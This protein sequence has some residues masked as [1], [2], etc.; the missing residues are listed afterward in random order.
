[1]AGR[2]R[3]AV[4]V[5]GGITGALTARELAEAGWDVTVLEAEHT[6]A[7]SSSRTAAGIRQ[8]FSTETTVRGMRYSVGFYERF[9][10]RVGGTVVPIQQQG[11][12]FL[13]DDEEALRRAGDRVAMQRAAGLREVELLDGDEVRRRHPWVDGAIVGA[14]FCPT[15]GFLLPEVVYNEAMEAARRLGAQVVQRAPVTGGSSEG[16]RLTA[17]ETPRGRFGAD[18]FVDATNAWTRR[19]ARAL[20]AEPLDVT[21]YKRFLWFLARGGSM[22]AD[23]LARMPMT[24]CPSGV[25]CRPENASSLMVG[26]VLD[27][28]PEPD[29]GY[30]DQDAVPPEF[31]HAGGIDSAAYAV[32]AELA[33]A[34]P[35]I[36]EFD[37]FTAT[38]SG[39]YGVTP[40]HNPFLGFDRQLGNLLRL[41]GFSGHGA[42][43]GPFTARVARE[44][45]EA[46]RDLPAIRLDGDTVSLDA[47]RIGRAYGAH[48]EL[49]I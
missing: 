13:F 1:M 17:V 32:W 21:P 43:F 44:L 42:M 29:F 16:G 10:Q 15:D 45:A 40:D 22:T 46:G 36:G 35:P 19:T 24:V 25:Y 12:L 4:V 48:E 39:Y 20:G 23:E 30:A 49:V 34:V 2:D 3:R 5:G 14:T 26:K 11:Y 41:V 7:G 6:G 37:G 27:T 33:E 8:Q 18:L 31:S 38:T 28:R 9:T 47:F